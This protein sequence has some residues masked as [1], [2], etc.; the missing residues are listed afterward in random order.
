MQFPFMRS[1]VA[2]RCNGDRGLCQ[3]RRDP[4]PL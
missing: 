4:K 1:A 2:A 3:L